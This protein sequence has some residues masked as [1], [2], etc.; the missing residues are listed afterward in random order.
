MN[1]KH[2]PLGLLCLSLTLLVWGVVELLNPDA[3]SVFLREPAEAGRLV[4]LGFLGIAYVT[5][6]K[7]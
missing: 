6:L 2:L 1:W 7:R 3:T 5:W 4:A